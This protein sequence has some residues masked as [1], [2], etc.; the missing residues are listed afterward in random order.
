MSILAGIP[1]VIDARDTR[2]REMAEFFD[3]PVL[4]SGA[5]TQKIDLYQLYETTDYTKF[6]T[7][8]GERYDEFE[9]FLQTHGIVKRINKNN[10]FFKSD[11]S[12]TKQAHVETSDGLN[13]I[14]RKHRFS[15]A[16]YDF[17]LRKS[18]QI[19]GLR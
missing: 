17:L 7:R 12:E 2:T 18:R 13:D 19:R 16:A 14:L 8:I 1:A 11:H 6:N 9:R 4:I 15:F 5:K 10:L 3:I